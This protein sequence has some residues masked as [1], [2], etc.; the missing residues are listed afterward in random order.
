M[1]DR[2]HS[3]A[4]MSSSAATSSRSNVTSM[5]QIPQHKRSLS[6]NHHLSYN[7]YS[8]PGNSA[9]LS[10]SKHDSNSQIHLRDKSVDQMAAAAH[11]ARNNLKGMCVHRFRSLHF[12]Y[13]SISFWP[14]YS[15][16][17]TGALSIYVRHRH[18]V[19]HSSTIVVIV[20][21]LLAEQFC[22]MHGKLN[23]H[24]KKMPWF[25]VSLKRIASPIRIHLEML[26]IQVSHPHPYPFS[27]ELVFGFGLFFS[28]GWLKQ[29]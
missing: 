8:S 23:P 14:F 16:Q 2:S 15:R 26:Y 27:F 9:T 29:N 12:P 21:H 7:Q 25:C 22:R 1:S 10:H 11:G 3:Q 19:R 24:T 20:V 6:F 28:V 13:F 5:Q 17:L 18:Y 4:T